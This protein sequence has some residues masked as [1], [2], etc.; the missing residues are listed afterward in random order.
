MAFPPP[1]VLSVLLLLPW[2]L[3]ARR[4]GSRLWTGVLLSLFK[5]RSRG[6]WGLSFFEENLGDTIFKRV[7][8][9]TAAPLSPQAKA[10]CSWKMLNECLSALPPS[11]QA[12]T[13]KT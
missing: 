1:A 11:W 6:T 8:M 10:A 7:E 4:R 12:S 13:M 9:W 5:G 3:S 2:M